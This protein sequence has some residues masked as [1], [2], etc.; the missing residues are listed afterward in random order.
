M[1]MAIIEKEEVEEEQKRKQ[2]EK[3]KEEIEKNPET[4]E[5][6]DRIER[7]LE[8]DMKYGELKT[9]AKTEFPEM[10]AL[11]DT[12]EVYTKRIPVIKEISAVRLTEEEKEREVQ[13]EEHR[14]E[15]KKKE[16]QIKE[17]SKKEKEK[18]QR[19]IK[20]REREF[21]QKESIKRAQREKRD[22]K[23]IAEELRRKGMITS[24]RGRMVSRSRRQQKKMKIIKK[25]LGRIK[26]IMK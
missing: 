20:V 7:G 18:Q 19:Q 10:K 12:G 8:K 5:H 25:L 21:I 9:F 26:K 14:K 23:K 11:L 22:I 1:Q 6:K 17:V 2:K 4:Q 16:V 15:E 24:I 3:K 13:R